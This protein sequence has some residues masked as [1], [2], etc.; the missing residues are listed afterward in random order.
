MWVTR[1]ASV[2]VRPPAVAGS[3]YPALPQ[4][5][6]TLVDRQIASAGELAGSR[7]WPATERLLGLLVP[8]AGLD[9]SGVVAA[10]GWRLLRAPASSPT[11]APTVVLLGTNHR[12]GWLDGVGVWARGS[13]STPLGDVSVDQELADSVLALGSPFAEDPRAHLEEHSIEVQLPFLERLVPAARIVPLAVSAGIGSGAL[14]AGARLG[15]LLAQRLAAGDRMVVAISSDMAHY[16]PHEAAERITDRLLPA[17][18]DRDPVELA[19]RERSVVGDGFGSV[20][21]GM[22]GIEPAVLGLA[23]LEAIPAGRGRRLAA[24]TSAEAGGSPDRT[25][26]YLAVGFSAG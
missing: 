13:W 18:L 2:T 23:A 21:C 19:R 4:A 25:V 26:G 11:T 14:D 1:P 10:A 9:Y 5:L 7:A 22:C 6:A 20:A 16:P 8:H 15:T 3:F 17:I 12:A 24:A